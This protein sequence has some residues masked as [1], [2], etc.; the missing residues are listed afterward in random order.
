MR[1]V[2]QVKSAL[3]VNI[4]T[5]SQ[6]CGYAASLYHTATKLQKV[7]ENKKIKLEKSLHSVDK[8]EHHAPVGDGTE[9]HKNVPD[10]MEMTLFVVSKEIGSA[11]V[12]YALGQEKGYGKP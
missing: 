11:G 8:A 3:S 5:L 10:G 4:K 7:F 1:V 2:E 6:L 12:E 9:E